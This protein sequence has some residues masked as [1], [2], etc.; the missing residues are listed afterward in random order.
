[1]KAQAGTSN[2]VCTGVM[3]DD[4]RAAEGAKPETSVIK[5]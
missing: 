1:M 5:L 4:D 3:S 2:A